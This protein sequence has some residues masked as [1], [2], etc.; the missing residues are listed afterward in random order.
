VGTGYN[1]PIYD[2]NGNP[3]YGA[4]LPGQTWKLFM[5]TYLAGKPNLP[6]ATKQLI[7]ANGGLPAP[8]P[9]A[10]P[11]PTPSKTKTPTPTFTVT[12]GF[13]STS[14]PPSTSPTPTPS[15]SPSCKQ[16]LVGPTCP[17]SSTS[18]PAP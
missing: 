15:P 6:M 14:R 3:L 9:T 7:A 11:T 16:G 18:P 13:P 17:S 10:T 2:S 5:D 8:T 4:N 12:S 1:R